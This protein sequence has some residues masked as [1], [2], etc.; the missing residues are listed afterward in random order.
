MRNRSEF[1]WYYLLLVLLLTAMVVAVPVSAKYIKRTDDVNNKLKPADSVNPPIEESFNG[2]IKE[3][4]YFRTDETDNKTDYPVYFRVKILITW[5][6][7]VPYETETDDNTDTVP[8]NPQDYEAEGLGEYVVHFKEPVKGKDYILTL[9]G[10]EEWVYNKAD[11][12]YYYTELVP[13]GGQTKALIEKCELLKDTINPPED[14]WRLSVE[15]IV[16][17]VQAIGHTDESDN[18]RPAYQDAWGVNFN[19]LKNITNP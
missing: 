19:D 2:E 1:T 16:Q 6:K 3:N 17:T 10:N 12:Y 14:G 8:E 15:L 18:E 9:A 4:V 7:W 13:S 11:D 5:K